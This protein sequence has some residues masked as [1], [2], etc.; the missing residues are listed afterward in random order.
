[1]K[2]EWTG[3]STYRMSWA[4]ATII[5]LLVPVHFFVPCEASSRLGLAGGT[6]LIATLVLCLLEKRRNRF[7]PLIVAVLGLFGH[8]VCAH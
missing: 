1:M 8:M 2:L 7:K 3:L 4:T 5:I 6:L